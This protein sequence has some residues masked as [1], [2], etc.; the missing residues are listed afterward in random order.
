MKLAELRSDQIAGLPLHGQ[1]WDAVAGSWQSAGINNQPG[2][3]EPKTKLK[4]AGAPAFHAATK[5]ARKELV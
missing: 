4:K 2:F 1:V 3:T 5:T